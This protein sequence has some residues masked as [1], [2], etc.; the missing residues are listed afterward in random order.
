MLSSYSAAASRSLAD[1]DGLAYVAHLEAGEAR[2]E[3]FSPSLPMTPAI[4]W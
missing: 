3:M 4:N 1:G 2:T